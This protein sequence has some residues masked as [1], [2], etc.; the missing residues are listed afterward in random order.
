MSSPV[1][2]AKIDC[3][4]F[5]KVASQ[6]EI[7][8]F[9]TLLLFV[10]PHWSDQFD[11]LKLSAKSSAKEMAVFINEELKSKNRSVKDEL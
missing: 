4:R 11:S 9:P 6:L 5:S 7:K 2:M 3:E 8:G 1:L 10:K